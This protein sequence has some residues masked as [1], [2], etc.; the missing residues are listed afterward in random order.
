MRD[1]GRS[2]LL[3]QGPCTPFF[4]RLGERLGARGH[5]VHVVNFNAG[6]RLYRRGLTQHHFRGRLEQLPTFLADLYQRYAITDQVMFGD[7]RPVHRPAIAVAR[8]RGVRNHV[9][10]EGYLRPF[11]V[12]LEREGVNA[13]SLLPRDPAW[14]RQVAPRLDPAPATSRFRTRFRVRAMHDVAYHLAGLVNPLTFPAYR[15]HAPVTAPRE[16]LGYIKRFTR[17]RITR[18]HRRD[19][20]CIQQLATGH[21]PYFVLALQLNGDAQIRDHSP[22]KDMR[23]VIDT[24]LRSFAA[25]AVPEARLVVKNHPLDMGLVDYAAPLNRL[26]AE[27]G[28]T[29]RIH[30]LETGDL[31]L[32]LKKAAGMVTVNSTSGLVALENGCPT[33]TLSDPIYALPGLTHAG[34]LDKFWTQATPPDRALLQAFLTTL[35]HCAQINGGFYCRQ[36]IELAITHALPQLEAEHSTLESWLSCLSNAA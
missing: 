24:T 6:D 25:H 16:Y 26:E 2:F 28:L 29:G 31:N 5:R 8:S 27:L 34:S 30:Y 10:E 17:L 19:S 3:L 13:H 4:R 15:N 36:G 9:F 18:C 7:R 33:L 20:A 14:Y 1:Q 35:L 11:W 23:Q 22:F 32:L 21:A 12:T